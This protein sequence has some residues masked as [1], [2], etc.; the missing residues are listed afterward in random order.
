MAR[1]I[2]S[3]IYGLKRVAI[4]SG[5]PVSSAWIGTIG[6]KMSAS[7]GNCQALTDGQNA[8]PTRRKWGLDRVRAEKERG[9]KK[10]S[11]TERPEQRLRAGVDE[12]TTGCCLWLTVDGSADNAFTDGSPLQ[13]RRG[14]L[15]SAGCGLLSGRARL[16]DRYRLARGSLGCRDLVVAAAGDRCH[17]HDYDLT[18]GCTADRLSNRFAAGDLTNRFTADGLGGDGFIDDRLTADRFAAA[19]STVMAMPSPASLCLPARHD[20]RHAGEHA[21]NTHQILA[22]HGRKPL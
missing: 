1:E 14:C 13:C 17:R 11:R 5:V 12:S 4:A 22:N 10:N 3:G 21:N 7:F 8:A 9:R 19:C 2:A 20:H 15:D 6:V 16:D 18:L